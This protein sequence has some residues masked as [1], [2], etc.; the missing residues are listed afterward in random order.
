LIAYNSKT[1]EYRVLSFEELP[2][3]DEV[4]LPVEGLGVK[5]TTASE[6]EIVEGVKQGLI[7]QL[8]EN[9]TYAI[10]KRVE[11]HEERNCAL[12]IY[13]EERTEQIKNTIAKIRNAYLQIKQNILNATSLAE[14]VELKKSIEVSE[15]EKLAGV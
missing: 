14:L 13:D 12:G 1:N 15:I 2:Q 8:K 7:R 11:V 3:P 6:T 9:T 10:R 4:A 5:I